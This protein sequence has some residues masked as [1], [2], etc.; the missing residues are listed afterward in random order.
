MMHSSI[1]AIKEK[2]KQEDIAVEGKMLQEEQLTGPPGPEGPPGFDGENGENGENGLQGL[3]GVPG[4]QGGAGG[5]GLTGPQGPRGPP[6]TPGDSGT[7]GGRGLPGPAGKA[8]PAGKKG[9]QSPDLDCTRIGGHMFQGVCF[10]GALLKADDDQL[11]A[12]CKP[13]TPQQKWGESD[14]WTLAQMFHTRAMTSR[15]D[16]GAHGGLCRNHL[17]VAS[18]TQNEDKVKV[19]VNSNTFDF[20]PTGAGSSCTLYNG[21]ATMAIYACVV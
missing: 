5:A 8:G 1:F 16:K 21:D 12:D 14:W 15:I 10:K 11:P 3:E 6:G 2:V 20:K 17:A 19:W 18:F 13:W 7:F 4:K 9:P